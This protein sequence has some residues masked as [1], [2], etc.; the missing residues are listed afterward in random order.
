ML[1]ILHT[2][3][4]RKS[5][6]YPAEYNVKY[7]AEDFPMISET[8]IIY[9][10]LKCT[11]CCRV[12]IASDYNFRTNKLFTDEDDKLNDERFVMDMEFDLNEYIRK[13]KGSWEQCILLRPLNLSRD[14]QFFEFYSYKMIVS[15]IY[16][17]RVH[18]IRGGANVNSRLIIWEKKPPLDAGTA[19][20]RF[21]Y[22]RD[23]N[24]DNSE[25]WMGYK[26]HF[27]LPFSTATDL[28]YEAALDFQT[29]DGNKNNKYSTDAY[30]IKAAKCNNDEPKQIFTLIFV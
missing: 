17:K 14:L 18:D 1:F 5:T 27:Y 6:D 24:Y 21:N 19:N 10:R 20:Q 30:Q 4:I 11:T 26:K 25:N 13:P 29:W 15:Y 12:V 2:Y 3:A 8:T 9:D 16:P 7:P 23:Y 22:V 28:C